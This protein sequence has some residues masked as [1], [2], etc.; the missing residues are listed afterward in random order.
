MGGSSVDG[1]VVF[2]LRNVLPELLDNFAVT[3]C[4]VKGNN[5]NDN[6]S[7]LIKLLHK[8]C[9]LF[10]LLAIKNKSMLARLTGR[11]CRVEG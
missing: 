8:V 11:K 7:N 5:N 1:V 9:V 6:N 2:A 10:L 3:F 4:K